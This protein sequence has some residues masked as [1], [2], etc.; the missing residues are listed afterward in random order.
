[1]RELV[2]LGSADPA[3]DTGRLPPDPDPRFDRVE[4]VE[5]DYFRL[6]RFRA[7]RPVLVERKELRRQLEPRKVNAFLVQ[8]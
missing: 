4:T 3:F 5:T 7:A 2:L 6:I 8:R 1:M